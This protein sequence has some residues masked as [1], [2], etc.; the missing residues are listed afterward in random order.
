MPVLAEG[1]TT[2][3]PAHREEAMPCVAAMAD[4]LSDPDVC[5]VSLLSSPGCTTLIVDCASGFVDWALGSDNPRMAISPCLANTS[6]SYRVDERIIRFVSHALSVC[7]AIDSSE[8]TVL[9]S[10]VYY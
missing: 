10:T 2:N 9:Y 6:V 3:M 7:F 1:S 4:I 8:Q 5:W